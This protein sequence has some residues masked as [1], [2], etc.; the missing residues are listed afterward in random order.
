MLRD[1]IQ[2]SICLHFIGKEA[3][4]YQK[5]STRWHFSPQLSKGVWGLTLEPAG[6]LST[7]SLF[8]SAHLLVSSTD[9]FTNSRFTMEL[10]LISSGSGGGGG[11]GSTLRLQSTKISVTEIRR[12]V[13]SLLRAHRDPHSS[14]LPSFDCFIGWWNHF[15]G[16]KFPMI[17]LALSEYK[18]LI[19]LLLY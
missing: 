6:H 9:T 5:S 17:M 11:L 2:H 12:T 15:Q 19:C 13:A 3:N 7:W 8:I 1:H 14:V 4:I 16:A 18:L 10:I